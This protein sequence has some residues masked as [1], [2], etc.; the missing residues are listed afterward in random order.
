MKV[1]K[2][3]FPLLVIGMLVALPASAVINRPQD[4]EA[5]VEAPLNM[6]DLNTADANTMVRIVKNI[7]NWVAGIILIV[8]VVV[9][10]V[11]AFFYM[12]SGGDATKLTKARGWVVGGVI[13]IFVSALAYGI[14]RIVM[15]V[16]SDFTG[17]M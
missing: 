14:V 15:N 2:Y 4:I 17:G 12:T 9:I 8:A 13:G 10:L 5:N 3:I 7:Q 16:I 6:P 11:G 1:L